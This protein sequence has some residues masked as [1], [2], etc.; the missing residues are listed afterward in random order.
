MS[1]AQM[2]VL[3]G[4]IVLA[5]L[6]VVGALLTRVVFVALGR[7]APAAVGDPG[8]IRPTTVAGASRLFA[9]IWSAEIAAE[10]DARTAAAIRLLRILH[11][12]YVA[13]FAVALWAFLAG[14]LRG[15]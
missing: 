7:R 15:A 3:G 13:I 2:I 10:V 8:D 5:L 6:V 1:E 11:V 4:V 14:V 9:A 12:L